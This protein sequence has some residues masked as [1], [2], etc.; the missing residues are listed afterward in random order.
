MHSKISR[1]FISRQDFQLQYL[2]SMPNRLRYSE[3]CHRC[4]YFSDRRGGG[5]TRRWPSEITPVIWTTKNLWPHSRL[6]LQ[7][8]ITRRDTLLETEEVD[9]SSVDNTCLICNM[10]I[11][12]AQ[13]HD[14]FHLSKC[15]LKL[16]I[17]RRREDRGP[18][19]G[20]SGGRRVYFGR[21]RRSWG[22]CKITDRA[23]RLGEN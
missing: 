15:L 13:K 14:F 21:A 10:S 22:V 11:E 9:K 20:S 6:K 8:P 3:K 23:G 7:R 17:S 2:D 19:E 5:G 12:C 18:G 1:M 16:F 4:C